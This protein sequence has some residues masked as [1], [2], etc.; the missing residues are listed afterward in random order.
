MNATIIDGITVLTPADG[1]YLTNGSTYSQ[2]VFLGAH[3][4]AERWAEVDSIP[5]ADEDVDADAALAE[6]AEV[7]G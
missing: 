4:S 3:G 1:R 2:R 6:I 7:I 5:C